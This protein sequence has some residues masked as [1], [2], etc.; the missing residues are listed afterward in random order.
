MKSSKE[1]LAWRLGDAFVPEPFRTRLYIPWFEAQLNETTKIELNYWSWVHFASGMLFALLFRHR[2]LGTA[3]HWLA[4]H[5]LWELY[6]VSIGMTDL[7][8]TNRNTEIIDI[9][10]DTAFAMAGFYGARLLL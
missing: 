2:P 9:I 10:F 8:D 1:T 4:V 7:R 6:Q 5:S 3:W